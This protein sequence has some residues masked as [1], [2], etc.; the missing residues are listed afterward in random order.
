MQAVLFGRLCDGPTCRENPQPAIVEM[1]KVGGVHCDLC[2]YFWNKCQTARVRMKHIAD[3]RPVSMDGLVE[4]NKW[5]DTLKL[6]A[7][8]RSSLSQL[9]REKPERV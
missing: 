6:A 4:L 1:P 9:N 7:L 8:T 3:W 2:F 5:R